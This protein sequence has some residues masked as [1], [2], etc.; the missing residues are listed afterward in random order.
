V[1]LI[2]V[3]LGVE[4]EFEFEFEMGAGVVRLSISEKL[5]AQIS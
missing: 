2:G 4:F 5:C 1:K 3:R